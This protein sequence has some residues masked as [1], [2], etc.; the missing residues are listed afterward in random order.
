MPIH[1]TINSKNHAEGQVV[2]EFSLDVFH[3]CPLQI[4]L[5]FSEYPEN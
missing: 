4:P 2:V 3:L 1:T 5:L